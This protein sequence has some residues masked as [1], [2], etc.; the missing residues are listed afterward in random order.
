M[1]RLRLIRWARTDRSDRLF[2]KRIR[3]A[4]GMGM[5][6]AVIGA[7]R[8]GQIEKENI[9][10]E[11]SMEHRNGNGNRCWYQWNRNGG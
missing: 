11:K 5:Q 3:G 2:G 1:N 6:A 10:H 7:V 9:S 8:S 4:A